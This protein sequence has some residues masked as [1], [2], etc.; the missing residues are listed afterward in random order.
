MY[1][2]GA[3]AP[4]SAL[5]KKKKKKKKKKNSWSQMQTI[6]Q[7]KE[8]SRKKREKR[9]ERKKCANSERWRHHLHYCSHRLK[10]WRLVDNHAHAP[11]D[12]LV[13]FSTI[14]V[15]AANF[16]RPNHITHPR[17]LKTQSPHYSPKI[18]LISQTIF[19]MTHAT[20][21]DSIKTIARRPS[22]LSFYYCAIVIVSLR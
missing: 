10:L 22:A 12:Q 11:T 7:T 14:R 2:F 4:L 21:K 19:R 5:S 6:L 17:T 15:S 1:K 16:G 8:K 9:K 3:T 20:I 18:F 13:N